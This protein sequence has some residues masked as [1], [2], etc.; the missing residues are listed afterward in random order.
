MLALSLLSL[1]KALFVFSTLMLTENQI[2]LFK[3]LL[4]SWSDVQIADEK[5]RRVQPL[6][7][8]PHDRRL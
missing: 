6:S 5:C 2:H 7:S 4:L 3:P 8:L 1:C